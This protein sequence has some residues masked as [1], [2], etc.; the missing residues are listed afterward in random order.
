MK[1]FFIQLVALFILF[2]IAQFIIAQSPDTLWTK[3]FG[4]S[5]S[6]NGTAILQTSD[7]GYIFCGETFSFGA[8]ASDV[9]L[10]RTDANGDTLW[11]RTYG[12]GG[13]SYES[14]HSIRET[15][16]GGFIITGTIYDV[17]FDVLLIRI[18]ADGDTL[19]T[20]RFGGF[21]SENGYSVL[22]TPDNGF[23]V[24][25]QTRTFHAS[26]FGSSIWLIRTDQNGDTLW[27]KTYGGGSYQGGFSIN[28]TS[29]SGF[30][31]TGSYNNGGVNS[32]EVWL[33]RTDAGGD[34]L[35]TKTFG[36]PGSHEGYAVHQ[37][38]DNGFIIG[39]MNSWTHIWLIRTDENGDSL[40]TK[41]YEG[42]IGQT[43]T[44]NQVSDGGFILTGGNNFGD[45][46]IIR[47][48]AVGDTLWTKILGGIN[49]DYGSEIIQTSDGGYIL[50]GTT[51]SFGSG[52]SD[53][54]LIRIEAED[55]IPVELSSFSAKINGNNVE[56][57]WATATET[58]NSGF[59]IER[60]Q[61]SKSTVHEWESIGYLVG[62]G[63]T[64]E[65]NSYSF[66]DK[67]ILPGSYSY[68]LKQIDFDG[69]FDYSAVVE[70]NIFLPGEFILHQNYPNPFN[71]STTIKFSSGLNE[72]ASLKVFNIIGE[73]IAEIFNDTI[74][75]GKV[76]EVKFNAGNLSS[77]IY[78]YS[79][80]Q[81]SDAATE[82]MLL[83]K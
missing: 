50:V 33:L 20:R 9:W 12:G 8:G 30:V 13:G 75:A 59:E 69:S 18:N 15:S 79:L 58:N 22:Q 28:S 57:N 71:P 5:F 37:T 10:I 68:R 76:Y 46:L 55:P 64:T 61:N 14:A 16:D 41:M 31:I 45:L 4:G 54:W 82:K 78:Y 52:A 2:G 73:E 60:F 70:I 66:I 56:L 51:S 23:I 83:L 42:S 49:G 67:N 63:T 3:T 35:W 40:W 32:T 36:G 27:T 80:T 25:G 34:T 77:G 39:G 44:L 81:G 72:R 74:E 65:R 19:W 47:T 48:D 38:S 43:N 53:V 26:G 24:C 1:Q 6:D 7:N 17:V 21:D 62:S 29:D 11:T